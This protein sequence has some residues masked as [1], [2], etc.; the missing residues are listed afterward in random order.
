MQLLL[1]LN[2]ISHKLSLMYYADQM[3][4]VLMCT[5]IVLPVIL[6]HWSH[7]Q[8]MLSLSPWPANSSL[9]S[10]SFCKLIKICHQFTR[11]LHVSAHVF[12]SWEIRATSASK[13]YCKQ[14]IVQT[15]H[16]S[17]TPPV[18]SVLALLLTLLTAQI[19]PLTSAL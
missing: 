2:A 9:L 14:L 1:T 15:W 19:R 4:T 7:S 18:R 10:E 5:V 16:L 8:F 11:L 13:S 3:Q 6:S 12:I 17:G